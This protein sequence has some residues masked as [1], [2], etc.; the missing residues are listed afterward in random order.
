M[1]VVHLLRKC[2]PAEWGGTETAVHRLVDG[3]NRHGVE[4]V[5]YCPQLGT[6][7]PRDPLAENGVKI[8]RFQTCVPI[9]GISREQK[10]QLVAVGGNLVS[11]DLFPALHRE[12]D[13]SV[14]HT[15]TLGRLAATALEVARR[16][17]LP[18][19]ITIHGGYLDLPPALKETLNRVEGF[20][21][22]RAIGLLLRTRRFFADAAAVLTCNEQEAALFRA[23]HPEKRVI[24]QPHGV[25]ADSYRQPCPESI[26]AFPQLRNR[27]FLLCVGRIDSVKNQGWVVEQMPEIIRKHPDTLLV[28]AGASTDEVYSAAL[29]RRI[30][31]LGLE[32]R[33]LLTGGLPPGD[34]R[35]IGLFQQARA[36]LLPSISETFG[37]VILEAWAAGTL[38]ISSRTSGGTGLIRHGENGWLFD[39]ENTRSFHEAINAALQVPELSRHLAAN[40]REL[41]LNQFDT[42]VLAGRMKSL[43]EQLVEQRND[44]S[45]QPAR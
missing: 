29:T 38:P 9:W 20:D 16:R 40:G 39:L 42:R 27:P 19:V 2:N 17:R 11:F 5:I 4:S 15:H 22:G 7:P 25:P 30:C 3:L 43:Y 44:G 28:L 33:V 41:V 32:Q 31:E 35:L 37:L 26:A 13:V 6:R 36:V 18:F 8:K 10:R 14:I 45:L 1:R 34:P 24:V 21:W 23:R 12:P